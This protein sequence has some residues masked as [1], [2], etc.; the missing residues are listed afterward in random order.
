MLSDSR[1]ISRP[2]ARAEAGV[3][4]E[5]TTVQ[6]VCVERSLNP[7][8]ALGNLDAKQS[9]TTTRPAESGGAAKPIHVEVDA[10]L[11]GLNNKRTQ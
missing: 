10:R 3:T 7:S 5:I 8:G 6:P 1:S 4:A 11:G 9:F 2:K